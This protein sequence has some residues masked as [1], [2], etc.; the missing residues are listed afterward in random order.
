MCLA[1]S[2]GEAD[3][4]Y[5][6][7]TETLSA[8]VP[9]GIVCLLAVKMFPISLHTKEVKVMTYEDVLSSNSILSVEMRQIYE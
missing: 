9:C 1:G 7:A 4:L 8:Q 6:G 2:S 3:G 5:F